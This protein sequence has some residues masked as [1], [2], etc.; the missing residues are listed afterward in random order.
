M[1]SGT[2][3]NRQWIVVLDDGTPVVDWGNGSGVDLISGNFVRFQENRYSHVIQD[4]ELDVLKRAGQVS[5]YDSQVVFI[6]SLPE[7]P[8]H[9]M[10]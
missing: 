3:I 6:V 1:P 4:S 9:T 7:P 8:H 10:E 5:S 2:P